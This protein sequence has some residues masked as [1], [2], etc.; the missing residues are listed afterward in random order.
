MAFTA[1]ARSCVFLLG[2]GGLAL[3][4]SGC[5]TSP[6]GSSAFAAATAPAPASAG[7]ATNPTL[8]AVTTR[9]AVKGAKSKPWF[10]TQR[11]SQPSNV[12]IQLSAPGD[13]VFS[14]VGL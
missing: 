11:A 1:F 10:G 4:V 8:T 5:S 14:A 13:G 2:L 12:R 9:N 6:E 7:I 3:G